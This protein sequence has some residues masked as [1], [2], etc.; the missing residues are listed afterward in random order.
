MTSLFAL[1]GDVAVVTGGAS[2]IGRAVAEALAGHGAKVAILD[3]DQRAASAAADIGGAGYV[4]DVRDRAAV[5]AAWR[6][7]TAEVGT[8]AML[9]NSAG[10][11]GW[12]D[13][14]DYPE[15]LWR[16]VMD[17]NL[18]GTFN[19]CITAARAMAERGQGAIV[20]IASVMGL[21]AVPGLIGYAASKG[22]VIQVTRAL[23]VEL[24]ESGVRVNAVAPSTFETPLVS[25]NRAARPDVYEMLRQRTPVKRFGEMSEIVGPVI[26]LLSQAASMVNG[27]VLAVDGGHLAA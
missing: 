5:Q 25:R 26:F 2:G 17:I 15:Q 24:A 22:G 1:T 12:G 10:V 9:V 8:P 4:A 23:A 11:G 21:M 14:L 7:I 18:T 20:N 16:D 27:H 3:R 13:A 6:D 19:C